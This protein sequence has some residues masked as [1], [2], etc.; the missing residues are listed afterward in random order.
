MKLTNGTLCPICESGKLSA[1]QKDIDFNYKGHIRFFNKT[2]FACPEC[3]E[4]FLES[5]DQKQIDKKLTDFRRGIDGLLTS[6]EI[7]QI[8]KKFGYTQVDFAKLLKVGEKNFARYESGQATQS[9]SM[10]SL[11]RILNHSPASIE[12]IGGELVKWDLNLSE[13]ALDVPSHDED[14]Y[15]K[16]NGERES[17][18]PENFSQQYELKMTQKTP[19]SVTSVLDRLGVITDD[20][21]LNAEIAGTA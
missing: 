12:V 6:N 17:G 1:I 8:R 10:D 14:F 11:L 3:E 16:G 9:R 4:E 5:A 7:K 15:F 19:N 18:V 21:A 13:Y 2:V 20:Y